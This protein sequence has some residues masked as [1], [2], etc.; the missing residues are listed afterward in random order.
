MI[1]V[2]KKRWLSDGDLLAEEGHTMVPM[3][4]YVGSPGSGEEGAQP[5]AVRISCG[6][7][8][9]MDCHSHMSE[10][11]EIIGLLGEHTAQFV[12]LSRQWLICFCLF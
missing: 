7:K 1:F 10:R 9:V 3:E 4:R 8:V 11:H 2:Q 5:F 6:C 12:R